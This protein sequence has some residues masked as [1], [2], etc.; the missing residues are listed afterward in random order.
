MGRPSILLRFSKATR[1]S[2][3]S[4]NVNAFRIILIGYAWLLV[5]SIRI[6]DI[7]LSLKRFY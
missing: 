3:G 5:M 2:E 4:L 7:T 1:S 6:S